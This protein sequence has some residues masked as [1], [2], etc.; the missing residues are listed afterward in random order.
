LITHC[1]ELLIES[2]AELELHTRALLLTNP[3][4]ETRHSFQRFRTFLELVSGAKNE[5]V[6]P[7]TVKELALVPAKVHAPS[8][9]IT[10]AKLILHSKLVMETLK[11]SIFE[12]YSVYDQMKQSSKVG[13]IIKNLN[14]SASDL[15]HYNQMSTME[16]LMKD[17]ENCVQNGLRHFIQFPKIE[18]ATKNHLVTE[19]TMP[20]MLLHAVK[21]LRL[22]NGKL[23]YVANESEMAL[24][25]TPSLGSMFTQ[26]YM[27]DYTAI[28][29]RLLQARLEKRTSSTC[30]PCFIYKA[31]MVT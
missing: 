1:H 22:H 20:V 21:F 11:S 24:D 17:T 2:V 15:S 5:D 8:V 13:K 6:A 27:K 9:A 3:Q 4:L 28:M 12:F 26:E 18:N 25:D 30:A 23:T 7:P 14:N 10:P 16:A 31:I 19:A 29:S